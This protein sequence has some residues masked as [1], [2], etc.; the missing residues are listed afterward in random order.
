[1][2]GHDVEGVRVFR[3]AP[4][5]NGYL[6]RGHALSA[7]LN[8]RA[9]E[10]TGGRFLVRMEDIDRTRTHQ[11]FET[12]V[13]EDLRWLGLHW[14]EPVLRQRDRFAAYRDALSKLDRL[15]LLYP[16]FMSRSE[17]ERKVREIEASGT[18][19]PRDP[20]GSWHYPG[21]ER[22]WSERRRREPSE[23]SEP[24]ALRLDMKRALTAL[25]KLDWAEVD[26]SGVAPGEI[27][28]ADPAEWGDVV[29]ARKEMPASYHLS[30]V[31]DDAFQDVTDIVRG[32]DL[33]S[34]TSVHRVLQ[35]LLGLPA[36]RYFHHRLILDAEGRKL[37]KSR[38]SETIRAR[39]A[40]GES[41]A[42]LIAGLGL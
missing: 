4:T 26:P 9:A 41:A 1:L 21:P 18:P 38:G 3:F 5:P 2:P 13:F 25:P 37:S 42:E 40:M 15:G 22:D 31:V 19:W 17:I 8:Q 30:V 39:R 35:T 33:A 28:A 14:E 27:R 6:H 29:L 7:L 34:S 16:S 24:F 36:P 12:A 11:R 32:N 23:G 10:Q 20:D